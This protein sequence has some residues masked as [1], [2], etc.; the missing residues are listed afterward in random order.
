MNFPV[1]LNRKQEITR[2]AGVQK[3]TRVEPVEAVQ[4]TA[5]Q[6][7]LGNSQNLFLIN[8]KAWE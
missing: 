4:Q 7:S 1:L 2:D 3:K 6:N 5:L 8:N